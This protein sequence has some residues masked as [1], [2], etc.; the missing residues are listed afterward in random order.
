MKK[1]LGLLLLGA[2]AVSTGAGCYV[3]DRPAVYA[4]GPRVWVPA[5]WA[6]NGGVRV[7]VPGHWRRA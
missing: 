6:W 1:L 3:Q 5:H 7:W 4:P 2:V